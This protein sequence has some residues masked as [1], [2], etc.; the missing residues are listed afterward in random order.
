[1]EDKFSAVQTQQ[2]QAQATAVEAKMTS[3][4]ALLEAEK[5]KLQQQAALLH[6]EQ[7]LQEQVKS[8]ELVA[9]KAETEIQ[10]VADLLPKHQQYMEA[11]R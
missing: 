10:S 6:T 4:R 2:M 1:M 8:T 11:L 5:V 9:R 7:K 3:E